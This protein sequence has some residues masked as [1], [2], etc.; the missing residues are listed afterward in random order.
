MLPKIFK[1]VN[2]YDLIRLGKNNDGGYLVEKESLAEAK[3]LIS[4]GIAF[5]WSFEKHFLK[6]K[7]CPIHCYDPFIKYSN[8]KKFSRKSLI[9]LFKI[10]NLFNKRLL[11]ETIN[12]IFL[13]NDYKKFFSKEV[14]HYESSIGVGNNKVDFSETI[15]KINSYPIF[16]KIDIEGSEYRILDDLINYQDKISGLVIEFHNIDLHKDIISNFIKKFSLSLCHIHGQNPLGSNYL[17]SN[18]DPIQIEMT[19]SKSKN[20]LSPKPKIPHPLD[21]PADFRFQD[22]ELNFMD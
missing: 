7:N 8:I 17:D 11:K 5:D 2:E 16:L 4:F 12:N 22:V 6:I 20:I 13:Y 14:V 19:F 21:Q 15:K 10:K 9:D 18:N 1:P 3:S